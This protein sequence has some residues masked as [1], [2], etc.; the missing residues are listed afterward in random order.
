MILLHFMSIVGYDFEN[1]KI[2]YHD[3]SNIYAYVIL[4]QY[5]MFF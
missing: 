1:K 2:I 5:N 4:L 3:T